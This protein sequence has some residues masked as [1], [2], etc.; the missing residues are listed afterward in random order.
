MCEVALGNGT[1]HHDG[2]S[3]C[4]KCRRETDELVL[5]CSM[6]SRSMHDTCC[7]DVLAT[8]SG[9]LLEMESPLS[10]IESLPS[11]VAE[12]LATPGFLISL[13]NPVGVAGRISLFLLCLF[14]ELYGMEYARDRLQQYICLARLIWCKLCARWLV[15]ADGEGDRHVAV[16]AIL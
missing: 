15:G 11:P 8:V 4:Q 1:G 9:K 7:K 12:H 6:C 13:T 3:E 16:T 10:Q 14:G 5:T 2:F